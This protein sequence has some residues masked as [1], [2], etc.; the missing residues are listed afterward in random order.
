MIT[1]DLTIAEVLKLNP[2]SADIFMRHG[3]HCFG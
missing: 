2:K 1:K 3:M